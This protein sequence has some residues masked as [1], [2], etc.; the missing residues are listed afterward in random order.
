[1]RR[2]E[3]ITIPGERSDEPGQRDNGKT[4]LVT[5]M[6]AMQAEEWANRATL[7]L[8]PRLTREL[9]PAIAEQI[10]AAPS[11]TAIE[12]IGLLLGSIQFPEMRDLMRELLDNCIKI[13]VNPAMGEMGA[14]PLN[15]GGQ[16]SIE[17]VETIRRLRREALNLHTGFTLAAIMFDLVAA[18][19]QMSPLS[20][21][22]TSQTE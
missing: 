1:M 22:S 19:S 4:F 13:V 9:D 16:E 10:K 6:P 17:E 15:F 20:N 5:E 18:G 3:Y 2:K 21:A 14:Q 12:H 8:I 11:M 7:A